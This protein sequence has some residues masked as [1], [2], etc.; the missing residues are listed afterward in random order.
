MRI[1]SEKLWQVAHENIM[2]GERKHFHMKVK[3]LREVA[4]FETIFFAFDGG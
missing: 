3:F 1:F 2:K 4:L